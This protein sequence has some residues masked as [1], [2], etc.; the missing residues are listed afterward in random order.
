MSI[1]QIPLQTYNQTSIELWVYEFM[2]PQGDTDHL[3]DLCIK[4]VRKRFIQRNQ[5]WPIF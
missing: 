2:G 3:Q 5:F 4:F 1:L